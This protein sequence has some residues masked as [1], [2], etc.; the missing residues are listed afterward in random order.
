MIF[1]VLQA[2]RESFFNA[3]DLGATTNVLKQKKGQFAQ[4]H[5]DRLP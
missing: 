1:D 4:D 3:I 5:N 2:S